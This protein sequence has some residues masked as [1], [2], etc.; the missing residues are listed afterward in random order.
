MT[1]V[2][3]TTYYVRPDGTVAARERH[4]TIQTEQAPDPAAP[5]PQADADGSRTAAPVSPGP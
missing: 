4:T 3:F 5:S 1:F 2:V